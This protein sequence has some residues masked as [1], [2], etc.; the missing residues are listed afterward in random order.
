MEVRS[1]GKQGTK[2]PMLLLHGSLHSAWCW[3][4]FLRFFSSRGYETRAVSLR[5]TSKSSNEGAKGLPKLA[6]HVEDLSALIDAL[7]LQI[8]PI[9]VAHSLAGL[10]LAK[11]LEAGSSAQH[12]VFLC[13]TPPSGNGPMISRFLKKR[14]LLVF[15]RIVRGFVFKA[16][17]KDE[18][19]ARAIFFAP[20]DSDELV[21]DAVSHFSQDCGPILDLGDANANLPSRTCAPNSRRAS[22]IERAPPVTVLGATDDYLVD[23]PGVAEMADYFGTTHTMLEGFPHDAML[24][25]KW[26]LA[27]QTLYSKLGS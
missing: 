22:W 15:W 17:C 10:I 2:G 6:D 7:D 12:A 4:N 5:G 1:C 24:T 16:V 3:D 23:P 8:P 18:V 14:G 21:S 9:I 20:D 26:E 25:A 27:A 13:S 11:Y 19:L